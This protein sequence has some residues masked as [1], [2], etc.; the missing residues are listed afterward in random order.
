MYVSATATRALSFLEF[1]LSNLES[2]DIHATIFKTRLVVSSLPKLSEFQF[3][4]CLVIPSSFELDPNELSVI[5]KGV[6]P[7][8]GVSPS[9][10]DFWKRPHMLQE[11]MLQ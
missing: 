4:S 3:D 5:N 9:L 7:L 2:I 8:C 10:D 11:Q 6:T 1:Q